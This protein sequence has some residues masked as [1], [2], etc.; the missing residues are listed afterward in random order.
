MS[1]EKKR[2]LHLELM[3]V[4]A[5]C[6]VVFNHTKDAGF[7]LFSRYDADSVLFWVYL[8]LSIFDKLAV[9]LFLAI[10]GALM[11]HRPDEEIRKL[12]TGRIWKIAVILGVYSLVYYELK[13][14]GEGGKFSL[15][16]FAWSAYVA[17]VRG[18]LW[19][20]YLYLAYLMILPFLRIL[21][22]HMETHHFYYL[23]AMSVILT[24]ILPV[25]EYLFTR[26]GASLYN[27][28]KEPFFVNNAVIYPCLGY[29]LQ[30][31]IKREELPKI[32]LWLWIANIMA[33]IIS[34]WMT[35]YRGVVMGYMNEPASQMF[36]NSFIIFNCAAMYVTVRWLCEGKEL[37][38]IVTRA[39][40]SIGSCTFGIYLLHL[41]IPYYK[42]IIWM[43]D[44]G[45][46]DML[47]AVLGSAVAVG[48]CYLATLF[49][50]KIP[51]VRRLVGF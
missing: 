5:I 24:G 10:S 8:F 21:V 50:S 9:P 3:R 14:V 38:P 17:P 37:P 27:T 43:Q 29:Y 13:V 26:G 7:F 41:L 42:L 20:L 19:F 1:S 49:I 35:Y 31:R 22:R 40:L 30:H 16:D 28:L 32:I 36:H 51:I 48:V 44:A 11:L 6:F 15:H 4:I 18:H 12:W 39:V 23:F 45:M 33:I 2:Q 25:M 34:C 47:S 46:N